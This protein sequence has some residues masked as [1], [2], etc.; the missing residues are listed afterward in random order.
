MA[1]RYL[2]LTL[3]F[4]S[5]FSCKNDPKESLDALQGK[6]QSLLIDGDSEEMDIHASKIKLDSAFLLTK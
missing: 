5:V 6:V 2:I 4:L 1:F 3:V